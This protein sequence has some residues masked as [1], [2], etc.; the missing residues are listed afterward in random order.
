[1]SL[2]ALT[3]TVENHEMNERTGNVIENKG[4]V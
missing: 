2:T 4:A 1:M 3:L